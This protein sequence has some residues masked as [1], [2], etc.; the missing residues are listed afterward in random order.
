[1]G[2]NLL[3]ETPLAKV[4]AGSAPVGVYAP[5]A[6]EP[7]LVLAARLAMNATVGPEQAIRAIP[8]C[9]LGAEQLRSTFIEAR[10]SMT[11]RRR[12]SYLRVKPKVGFCSDTQTK[13]THGKGSK[14]T[15]D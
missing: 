1:M 2:C 15:K 9:N 10:L 6:V 7:C 12:D 5:S 11:L 4:Q 3:L 8:F 14:Q 13:E